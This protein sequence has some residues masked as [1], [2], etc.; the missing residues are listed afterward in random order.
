LN[1]II[2]KNVRIGDRVSIINAQNLQEKD[3]ECYNIREGIIVI[4]KGALIPSDSVI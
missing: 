4:P 3:D 2:D 1:A